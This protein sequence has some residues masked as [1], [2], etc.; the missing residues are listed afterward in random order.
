MASYLTKIVK[1]AFIGLLL[2]G[3]ATMEQ[4]PSPESDLYEKIELLAQKI[5]S[6]VA[7]KG[8]MR[9]AVVEVTDVWGRRN[10]LGAF[11][12]EKLTGSLRRTSSFDVVERKS[13]H[14]IFDE[15]KLGFT[16]MVDPAS[17]REA[18][19][20]LGVEAILVGTVT[21]LGRSVDLSVRLIHTET[22]MVLA[23]ADVQMG[24]DAGIR[25]L[26]TYARNLTLSMNIVAERF[27]NGRYEEVVVRE[28]GTLRS[29]DT[30][31]VHFSA[32]ADGYAYLFIYD[33]QGKIQKLF[34]DASTGSDNKI[35]GG[36]TYAVPSGD[37]WFELDEHTGVETIY[38]MVSYEPLKEIAG[39]FSERSD[40]F[41]R[42][43]SPLRGQ[44]GEFHIFS[45]RGLKEGEERKRLHIPV[46]TRGVRV[47]E[48]RPITY[49]LSDGTAIQKE[50]EV[51]EGGDRVVRAIRFYHR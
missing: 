32:N 30:F 6:Q 1:V 47:V 7:D 3:C 22:A 24:K 38:V 37:L 8:K 21:D 28:G 4:A 33:S 44:R 2:S 27:V 17:V 14:R 5:S 20:I 11:L 25:R 34:P 35:R 16:G 18:G 29:G 48:G 26:L 13:L 9:I 50:L 45:E 12:S 51:I 43:V 39:L 40:G 49:S 31:K 46:V 41:E 19:K 15:L 36:R 10:T 42:E 23:S